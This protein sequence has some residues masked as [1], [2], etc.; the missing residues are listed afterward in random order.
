MTVSRQLARWSKEQGANGIPDEVL[1]MAKGHIL[2]GIGLAIAARR[3]GFGNAGV[4]VARSIGG[5]PEARI[6]GSNDLLGAASAAFANGIL[7]HAL[8]FDDT[9]AGGL[10]HASAVTLPVALAVGQECRSTGLQVLQAAVIGYETVCRLGAASPHGFHARGFHATSTCGTISSSLVASMLMKLNERD[11]ISA[12]G[13]AGSAS[14]GLLE[15]L[16]DGSDTKIIHPGTASLNG[17]LA[18]RLAG[19]GAEGPETVIEG[20]RGLYRTLSAKNADIESIVQGLGSRWESLKITIKPYPV[21]QLIHA[22][23]DATVKA[24]KSVRLRAEDVSKVDL[25][26]HPDSIGIVCEPRKVKD[27]PRTQYDA[28]F[29]L[30]WCLAAV[31]VDGVIDF[32]TFAEESIGRAEVASLA[33]KVVIHEQP[34][35]GPAAS[36]RGKVRIHLI[37]G[38]TLLGEVAGSKG[39]PANRLSEIELSSKFHANCGWAPLA[40]ELEEIVLTLEVHGSL[41]Q[42]HDVAARIVAGEATK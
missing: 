32:G 28:K 17:V 10:V 5:S 40:K 13:I 15:F 14:S 22:S 26:A 23:I 9:H 12:L 2:D 24:C 16:E 39:S 18:A 21:C 38:T 8:D 31:M 37:D 6:L 35:I 27:V 3:G 42:L 34:E 33:Q 36:A 41:T 20:Q 7:I 30:P 4:I 11:T 1:A 29:S 25:W 19:A